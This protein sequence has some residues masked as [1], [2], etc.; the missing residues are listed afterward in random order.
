MPEAALFSASNIRIVSS[1]EELISTPF[2]CGSNA[3]CWPRTL[4]GDFAEVVTKLALAP[5]ITHLDAETLHALNLSPAGKKAVE[6]ML[7]DHDLLT[8]HGMLPTLDGING[9]VQPGETGLLRTDVCS[10]HCDSATCEADTW[11]C[12]YH[13]ASSEGLPNDQA[14]R[15]V[16]V[17]ETRARLLQI[18][19]GSDDE[20][21]VEWLNDHFYD[22][23]YQ[24]LP[25]AQPFTFGIGNLWRVATLHDG[26][27]VPPCI[28]R[29]PDPIPGQPRLLLIA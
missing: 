18:Y 19:G 3:F 13:G 29:A 17:P 27:Y 1:F 12:T 23:H 6:V 20:S 10:W 14:M 2:G 21:F 16:D 24:P 25:T 28:H 8:E 22:L 4:V 15:H 9:Y 7:A 5:G 11:L 26:C